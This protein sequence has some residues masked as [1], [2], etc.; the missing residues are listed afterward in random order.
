MKSLEKMGG[1]EGVVREGAE[2]DEG[3][4]DGDIE[5]R[6]GMEGEEFTGRV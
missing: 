2:I 6:C 1:G 5:K 3:D 4:R